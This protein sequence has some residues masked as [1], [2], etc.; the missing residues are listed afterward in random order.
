MIKYKFLLL[1]IVPFFQLKAQNLEVSITYK[2]SSE[3]L[4]A[5]IF[6]FTIDALADS[7]GKLVV[8]DEYLTSTGRSI[9]MEI[10]EGR[11]THQSSYTFIYRPNLEGK[12]EIESPAIWVD[13]E[14]IRSKTVQFEVKDL[15]PPKPKPTAEEELIEELRTNSDLR[16]SLLGDQALVEKNVEGKWEV[17]NIFSPEEL[18]VYFKKYAEE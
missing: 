11:T 15:A 9:S 6:K 17:V 12:F 1:L 14:K 13:G 18:L 2:K 3:G 16:I 8:N 5:V 4:E 7:L 10:K